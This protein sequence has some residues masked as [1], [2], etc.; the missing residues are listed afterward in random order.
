M[1]AKNALRLWAKSGLVWLLF[2]LV[3]GLYLG[4]TQQFGVASPHAHAG[5]LGGLWAI[6][7][8]YLFGRAA[9]DRPI[10]FA[11]W[12][13][14]LFNIGVAMH[15][16]ALWTVIMIAPQF[17]ALIGVGGL[18][19]TIATIWIIVTVWPIIGADGA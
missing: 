6:G 9:S 10:R 17:G 3:F 1:L 2:T 18:V 15:V 14:L 13:W 11:L 4:I 12:Q 7:F 8:S 5:L 16:V 19:I